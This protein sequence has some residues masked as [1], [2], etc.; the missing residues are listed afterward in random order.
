M[1]LRR[2]G[3]ISCRVTGSRR[4]SEDLPQE[5]LSDRSSVTITMVTPPANRAR[6]GR[7]NVRLGFCFADLII[8]VC[9]STAKTAKI[10]S[11][12]NFCLYGS[13]KSICYSDDHLRLF[14]FYFRF[15]LPFPP[16]SL[17]RWSGNYP[18]ITLSTPV[19]NLGPL[20]T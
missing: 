19:A 6:A 12:E 3:T 2:G 16:F 11:L 8:V 13:S 4:Y 18:Q 1:F 15:Q 7:E 9:Q 20:L 14:A 10:G 17:S 5:Q